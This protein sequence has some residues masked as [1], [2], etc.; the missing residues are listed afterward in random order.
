MRNTLIFACL[1]SYSA[2]TQ[3]K[4]EII[5]YTGTVLSV[6]PGYG[7]A[8]ETIEL[9]TKDDTYFFRIGPEYG[10]SILSKIKIGQTITLRASVNLKTRETLKLL[11]RK[12]IGIPYHEQILEIKLDNEWIAT[13]VMERK[14]SRWVTESKVFLEEKV[15]GDYFLDGIR[16]GLILDNGVVSFAIYAGIIH[17][18]DKLSPGNVVSFFGY[19]SAVNDRYLYPVQGVKEVYEF[20]PLEKVEG[21]I[22]AFV[23]KQNYSRI[24]LVINKDRFSFPG[25]L[26]KRI[27]SFANDQS[28]TIYYAGRPNEKTNLL[29]TIHAIIQGSDTLKISKNYYGDPDGKHDYKLAELDG[30][31]SRVNHSDRGKI[32]SLILGNDCYVE[33]DHKMAEQLGDYLTKG[34]HIKVAGDERIKKEGEIYERNYRIITPRK[35]VVDGKEFTLKN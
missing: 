6:R 35:V 22:S 20:T 11:K 17:S 2:F 15:I 14:F 5:E 30:K 26:A 8:L 10:Q 21:K 23:H 3:P 29:P 31:I 28:V 13:P 33:V 34:T 16:K 25:E 9:K 19:K 12:Y 32:I 18:M 1:L 24:G 27:E 7:F 4:F